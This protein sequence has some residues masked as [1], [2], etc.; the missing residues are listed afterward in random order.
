MG[1]FKTTRGK[2]ALG[3]YL[4]IALAGCAVGFLCFGLWGLVFALALSL[5]FGLLALVVDNLRNRRIAQ[6]TLEIDAIL[7]GDS[8]GLLMETGEGELAILRSE[9]YK[10]TVRLREQAEALTRDRRYL[11][12]S[13]AD[14]SHQ[15]RTPLTSLNLMVPL[16]ARPNLE[17]KRRAEL[18][19]DMSRQLQRI[20]WLVSAMLMISKIDA[21]TVTFRREPVSIARVIDQAKDPLSISMELKGQ[22][23][24]LQTQRG[25]E[26]FM[27]DL[28]WTVEAVGNILKN[29]MEHTPAGG[30]ITVSVSEN[31]LYTQIVVRDNGPG[32]DPEDLPHLFERFYR[33]KDAAGDS[34]GI[35]LALAQMIITRQNGTIKAENARDGG[36]QFTIRFYKGII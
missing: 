10:M 25:D 18:V 15:L 31:A 35:G 27:G 23:F 13:M 17:A 7:H 12:D 16:L 8:Q 24:T 36:C 20:D 11:A 19:Q 32:I 3:V 29:A 1:N 34:V 6:L 2:A 4:A 5:L 9:I 28:S 14:I 21:G 30:E 22:T 26:Q 33:G